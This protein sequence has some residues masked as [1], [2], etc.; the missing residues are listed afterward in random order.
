MN[1][2]LQKIIL[3]T[4]QL[5][6]S[7]GVSNKGGK[8]QKTEAHKILSLA[9][10]HHINQLDTAPAYGDSETT[11][12]DHGGEFQIISKT[13]PGS[14]EPLGTQVRSSLKNLKRDYLDTL[15]IHHEEE[16]V[17]EPGL[18]SQ[19]EDIKKQG[20]AKKIGV[21]VYSPEVCA[22]L[23][24]TY[25]IDVI[26]APYNVL[27]QRFVAPNMKQIFEQNSIEVHFR[28]IFLQGLF[29]LEPEKLPSNMAF[30]KDTLVALNQLA[31]KYETTPAW[32]S[33]SLAL[34]SPVSSGV[35]L[36]VTS[37][38]EL[39]EIVQKNLP[40]IGPQVFTDLDT[41]LPQVDSKLIDPRQ[42]N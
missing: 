9:E 32:L 12:G 41:I 16:L 34:N 24:N 19:L 23:C 20:L 10:S 39:K 4:V 5:G 14:D 6:V 1:P 33:L 37:E 31:K 25:D 26:Q 13:H 42:W 3:G 7:Y 8:V 17:K 28:S 36:G 2:Q 11:I 22:K 21:S 27:D 40:E 18:W 29:F 35:L 30:A 15:L 38:L